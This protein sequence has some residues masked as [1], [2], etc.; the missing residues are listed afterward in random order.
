MNK[1]TYLTFGMLLL[2]QCF[3]VAAQELPDDEA[4]IRQ[5]LTHYIQGR[6]G[7]DL[8]QLKSAYHPSAALKFVHP[9]TGAL[10]EWSLEEYL[11]RL[12]PGEKQNCSGAI[13]D[14]HIFNDAA[15]ATV[16]LTYHRLRFHD[17]ISLLKIEGKWLIVDKTFSRKPIE[18]AAIEGGFGSPRGKVL[19]RYGYDPSE[20][21]CEICTKQEYRD[22]SAD[23]PHD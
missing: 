8:D 5:T 19:E 16:M 4:Q 1:L 18:E 9:E 7:G 6:N 13:T 21:R 22:K 15:Q 12:T 14:I 11:G 10:A 17:Y 3:T 2:L 23:C 20:A